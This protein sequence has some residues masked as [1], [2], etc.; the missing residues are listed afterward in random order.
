MVVD[1]VLIDTDVIG[2]DQIFRKLRTYAG[3]VC[4]VEGDGLQGVRDRER[5]EDC[6]YGFSGPSKLQTII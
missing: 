4:W 5:N 6:F 2:M 1:V 3:M